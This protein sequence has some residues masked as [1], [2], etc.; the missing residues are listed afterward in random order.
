MRLAA[1]FMRPDECYR[2]RWE[3]VTWTNGRN[4]TILVTY[5]KTAA[6]RRTALFW[7]WGAAGILVSLALIGMIFLSFKK[8]HGWVVLLTHF[9][10]FLYWL[11]G[12]VLVA[13]GE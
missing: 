12:L 11:V 13:S 2:L 5:G 3:S 9:V 6:A 4:G 1:Q 7:E 10:V 8:R